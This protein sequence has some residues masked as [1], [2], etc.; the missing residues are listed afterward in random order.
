MSMKK[1][2]DTIGNQ[3]RDLPVRSAVPQPPCAPSETCSTY[4][5]F[6]VKIVYYF[7][8]LSFFDTPVPTPFTFTS[9]QSCWHQD[10]QPTN[11][12]TGHWLFLT[13][14]YIKFSC[15]TKNQIYL[16][17]LIITA[18]LVAFFRLRKTESWHTN[19]P[20]SFRDNGNCCV[21][22]HNVHATWQACST[23]CPQRL[24]TQNISQPFP[25]QSID[26]TPKQFAQVTSCLF[27]GTHN[28]LLNKNDLKYFQ[29]TLTSLVV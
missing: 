9:T 26:R 22:S 6:S 2:S 28:T 24:R 1:S 17:H 21:V 18:I 10:L 15:R 7:Y 13:Y 11:S 16:T 3:T 20:L 8:S 19:G 5:N 23:C 12:L 27:M 25:C 14:N 4:W 29:P